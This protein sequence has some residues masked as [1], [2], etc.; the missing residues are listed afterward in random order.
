MGVVIINMHVTGDNKMK[1][2]AQKYS[3][4]IS[5]QVNLYTTKNIKCNFNY[6][7]VL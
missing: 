2:F 4:G 5:S 3:E 7:Y 6:V 1:I